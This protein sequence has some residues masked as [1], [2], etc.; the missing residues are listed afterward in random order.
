MFFQL[1]YVKIEKWLTTPERILQPMWLYKQ[2]L[3]QLISFQVS[4]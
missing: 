4:Y 1:Y 2:V 3:A